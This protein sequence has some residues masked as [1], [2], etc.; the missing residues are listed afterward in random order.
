MNSKVLSIYKPSEP[1]KIDQEM[2]AK[3]PNIIKTVDEHSVLIN[4]TTP[5]NHPFWNQ[6]KKDG[7]FSLIVPKEYG[8]KKMSPSGLS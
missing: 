7:F 6:A 4:R 8:G 2:F 3:L 1:T 5:E